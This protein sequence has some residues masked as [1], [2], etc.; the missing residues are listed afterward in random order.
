MAAGGPF[1]F[2]PARLRFPADHPFFE[3]GDVHRHLYL[4][5]ALASAAE[6][7]ERPRT[8]EVF[9]HVAG[10]RQVFD[11]L[12]SYEHHY[13]ML[14]RNVCLSCKRSFPSAH[15]LDVHILEWHDALFQIMAEKHNMYQ[16]L[17]ESCP[18][19]FKSSK[20]RRDH[21]VNVHQYP[22]DFR[23]DKPLRSKSAKATRPQP[24]ESNVP[25]DV[26][27]EDWAQPAADAMEV[28]PSESAAESKPLP[29]MAS[30]VDRPAPE[31]Q[32]CKP[33]IPPTI[34]FGQG[35]TRGFK[36]KKKKA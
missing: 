36:G 21:L 20:D 23:F 11:T 33:R 32:L 30:A 25:M 28:G 1:R 27:A 22:S 12:E 3:D 8:A 31:R 14:H 7:P 10:C 6:A 19:K 35:A 16:C 2:L 5:E 17:V 13:N 24:R 29:G 26:N 34:C 9:C 15:L 18:Q 4:R